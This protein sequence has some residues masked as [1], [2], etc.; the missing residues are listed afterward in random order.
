MEWRASH[1]LIKDR[2]LA[3]DILQRLRKGGN[4][5]AL[6]KE[7]STCPSKAKGGDLGWFGPA[8]MVKEFEQAVTNAPNRL[9]PKL[10]RTQFGFHIIKK[11]GQK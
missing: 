2:K 5:S 7:F 9:I 6:A 3:E 10:I 8:K 11:T 1:I 4:F